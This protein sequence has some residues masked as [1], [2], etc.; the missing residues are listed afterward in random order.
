MATDV[1]WTSHGDHMAVCTNIKSSCCMPDTSRSYVNFKP[2]QNY[3][4]AQFM[5]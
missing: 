4:N 1:N 2:V 3:L 5:Y